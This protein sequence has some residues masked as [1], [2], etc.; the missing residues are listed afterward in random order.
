MS[1]SD[2]PEYYK[3]MN[4]A[5]AIDHALIVSHL[6]TL[7]SFHC[8]HYALGKLMEHE[9]YLGGYFATEEQKHEIESLKHEV[10][11][12]TMAFGWL[13]AKACIMADNGEDI[14]QVEFP[15]LWEECQQNLDEAPK[16]EEEEY[17]F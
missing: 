7:D 12:M 14:R 17:E 6:G 5:Q 4:A 16:P 8:P 3:E 9:R 1:E 10:N 11:R 15:A 2:Y 13:Y